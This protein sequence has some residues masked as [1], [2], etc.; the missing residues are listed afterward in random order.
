MEHYSQSDISTVT[1]QVDTEPIVRAVDEYLDHWLNERGLPGTL[2][3]AIRYAL[4]GGKRMRPTVVVLACEAV[5]GS[6]AAALPTAGAIEL[7]HCFSLIHDDLPAMDD[8]AMRRGR[9]TAHVQFGEATAI[10]AGDAMMS[11]AFE[12]AAEHDQR[13]ERA[14]A[15]VNELATA[16]TAMI[17]GQTHDTLGDFP[18]GLDDAA[19]LELIHRNKTAA[20]FRAA[21]RMGARCGDGNDAQIAALTRYGADLGMM[22]QIVDDLLDVTQ[23]AQHVGKATNKDE[24][25]GKRTA[26]GLLGVEGAREQVVRLQQQANAAIKPLG[27][28]ARPLIDLCDAMAVR[29]R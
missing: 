29:S 13:A 27:E 12:M 26:T 21:G 25:A 3:D 19:K 10:L 24:K 16:T 17:A 4:E 14:G 6:R 9:P 22:F 23:S 7:V 2:S 18:T 20:L 11:L 8:D 1:E 28:P 15:L 5:G